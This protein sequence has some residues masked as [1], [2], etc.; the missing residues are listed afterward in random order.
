MAEQNGY[1]PHS[2]Q[3]N[4]PQE[5]LIDNLAQN[6][7]ERPSVDEGLARAQKSGDHPS[8]SSPLP[9]AA[10]AELSFTASGEYLEFLSLFLTESRAV[11]IGFPKRQAL[12]VFLMENLEVAFWKYAQRMIPVELEALQIISP[13]EFE[14]Q[15]WAAFLSVMVPDQREQRTGVYH[16]SM[17]NIRNIAV[18]RW[19]YTTGTI[20]A[21]ASQASELSDDTFLQ[22]LEMILKVLYADVATDERYPVTEQQRKTVYDLLWPPHRPA[23]TTHELFRTVQRL[24]EESSFDFCRRHLPQALVHHEIAEA[25]QVELVWWHEIIKTQQDCEPTD[26]REREFT[27]QVS[28]KV[29][30]TWPRSLR[31]ATAHREMIYVNENEGNGLDRLT[32]PVA[33]YVRALGDEKTATTIEQLTA[34]T[35]ALL[36]KQ[37][38]E[39]LDPAWCHTRDWRSIRDGIKRRITQWGARLHPF[40]QKGICV[41]PIIQMLNRSDDRMY[42]MIQENGWLMD[43]GPK[44]QYY[45]I[46]QPPCERDCDDEADA[47]DET[48]YHEAS[49]GKEEDPQGNADDETNNEGYAESEISTADDHLGADAAGDDQNDVARLDWIDLVGTDWIDSA[50]ETQVTQDESGEAD[51]PGSPGTVVSWPPIIRDVERDIIW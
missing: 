36:L 3:D 26:A 8:W 17:T 48:E 42:V 41:V 39:W 27:A 19:D 10:S 49:I 23:V 45:D 6:L 20:R 1:L 2:I 47:Y 18:H 29:R 46:P 51:A 28:E 22:K 37:Y 15:T 21:A 34:E 25:E 11:D 38:E 9:D 14:P 32:D 7:S 43:A 4:L 35:K 16:G 5:S 44:P 30:Q 33:K 12:I 40:F 50:E 31:N 13:D 24:G